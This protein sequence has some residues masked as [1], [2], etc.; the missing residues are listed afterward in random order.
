MSRLDWRLVALFL[1]AAVATFWGVWTFIAWEAVR[2]EPEQAPPVLVVVSPAPATPSATLIPTATPREPLIEITPTTREP[3]PTS[4][5]S[6]T[7]EPTS[8]R[9]PA[10]PVQKG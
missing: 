9:V 1:V 8:T 2:P 3:T 4:T 7:V 6:P 5:P 10:S